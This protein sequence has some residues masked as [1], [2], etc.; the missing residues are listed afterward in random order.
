MPKKVKMRRMAVNEQNV[1][2]GWE[3]Y[4]DYIF[5]DDEKKIGKSVSSILKVLLLMMISTPLI[6]HAI[7]YVTYIL[8]NIDPMINIII[9]RSL[10]H[11]LLLHV[12]SYRE[13]QDLGKGV[14]MEAS[15]GKCSL[16]WCCDW[17]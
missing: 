14:T 10:T 12:C 4:Y 1:E 15:H 8:V 6:Q 5:P 17:W 16:C 11:S 3:E 2:L 13:S 7:I 9:A